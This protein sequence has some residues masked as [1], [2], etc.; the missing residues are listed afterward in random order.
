ME[1][2]KEKVTTTKIL[3]VVGMVVLILSNF[4]VFASYRKEE[5]KFIEGDGIIVLIAAVV[6]LIMLFLCKKQKFTLIP[7]VIAALVIV[8]DAYNMSDYSSRVSFGLGFYLAIIG[9]ILSIAYPF[10]YKGTES[11]E[12]KE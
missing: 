7:T 12:T 6:A 3:G 11:T 5:V 10:L 8:Y 1:K 9:A 2:L 4:F